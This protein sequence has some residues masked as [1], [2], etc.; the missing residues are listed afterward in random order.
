MTPLFPGF[1]PVESGHGGV[2][3]RALAGGAGPPVLLLHGYPQTRAM[4][5]R[6]A[7]SLARDRTVIVA[8]LRGYGDSDKPEETPGAGTYAK[9]AMAADQ[10]TLMH[11]LGF[12]R[13]AVAGHDRGGR[14]AHRMA[15]DFPERVHALAVLDIVP[16]LH[17][18]ENV[19]REMASS[20]FHWFFLSQGSGLPERM[21][22]ADHRAWL[23]SRFAG[24]HAGAWPFDERAMAEYER[25]FDEATIR[26]SCADY[27][28]AA[29]IDLDHD[30]ADRD[31]RDLVRVPV[32]ALWGAHS[33]VGRNFDV[34]TVWREYAEQV[35]GVAVPADH[36]V[37]EEAPAEVI[38]ALSGFCGGS[39]AR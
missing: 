18:F 32:L 24:R 27:R 30:R 10:V 19:D 36:Y 26:V 31:R 20:Y 2:R 29:G 34:T 39:D 13:F 33:Y 37:C 9:R 4:W 17:M 3:I 25:C 16:T 14:V 7:P 6:V 12:T 35:E 28:A 22:L 5:H 8:D 23:R 21:I 15:L 38:E 1:E 11:S